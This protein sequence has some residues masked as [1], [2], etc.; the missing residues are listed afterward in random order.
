MNL[1]YTALVMASVARWSGRAAISGRCFDITTVLYAYTDAVPEDG[2]GEEA[3][4]IRYTG[5]I[6]SCYF[7]PFGRT[8]KI[9]KPIKRDCDQ[10]LSMS[11]TL[12]C[13]ELESPASCRP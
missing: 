1:M 3:A 12:C 7:P 8:I 13:T 4:H 9:I 11:V 5:P 2:I 6:T 10:Y